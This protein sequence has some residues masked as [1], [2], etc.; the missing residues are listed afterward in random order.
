MK[1]GDFL[2]HYMKSDNPEKKKVIYNFKDE[3]GE[4]QSSPEMDTP[5]ESCQSFNHDMFIRRP[6]FKLQNSSSKQ[7]D[8]WMDSFEDKVHRR[9]G[10]HF[11]NKLELA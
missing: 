1:F 4:A 11:Q 3:L 7:F 8:D 6:V 9:D 2:E 10:I 5:K